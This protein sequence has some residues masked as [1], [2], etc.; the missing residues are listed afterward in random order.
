MA[1]SGSPTTT[2]SALPSGRALLYVLLFLSVQGCGT[3]LYGHHQDLMV[4]T[5]PPGAVARVGDQTCVTP[6]TLV[7]PR[8]SR[9]IVIAKDGGE[10][11]YDLDRRINFWATIVAGIWP[12]YFIGM[13]TDFATGGAYDIQPFTATLHE[14]EAGR[15]VAVG[16]PEAI[17]ELTK[18]EAEPEPEP[19]PPQRNSLALEVRRL[20]GGGLS[21]FNGTV[22]QIEYEHRLR[23]RAGI[24]A[25]SGRI[26]FVTKDRYVG[27][28]EDGTGYG[29]EIGIK[30]YLQM[31][32]LRGLSFALEYGYWKAD[33]DWTEDQGT[34][35]EVSGSGKGSLMSVTGRAGGRIWFTGDRFFLAPS[36]GI[37]FVNYRDP[38]A[39]NDGLIMLSGGLAFGTSW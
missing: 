33:I 18:R 26:E 3:I 11:E 24:V 23:G 35:F 28:H 36:I 25:R 7:V 34:P 37:A 6:C 16:A 14:A 17:P 2:T 38:F 10:R 9:T 1:Q 5:E 22:T 15:P 30:G 4:N 19:L 27:Y 39:E 20:V 31:R 32:T 21:R 12:G 13:I 8:K 29:A